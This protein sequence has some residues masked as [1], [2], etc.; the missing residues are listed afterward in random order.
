[1]NSGFEGLYFKHQAGGTTLALIPGRSAREAF[2]QVVVNDRAYYLPYA[3]EEY[4]ADGGMRVGASR[5]CRDG[6]QLDIRG[7]DLTLCGNIR[8]RGITPIRGD[9]MGPFRFFPMECRH[10]VVSMHHRLEGGLIMNGRAL[11]FTGGTGYIEG[12][13]GRSFP[14]SYTWAQCNC[15]ADGGADSSVMASA[16]RIPFLGLRFWGCIA[17]VWHGGREYRLATYRGARVLERTP[18]ELVADISENGIVMSGGG[19]LL[20]GIDRLVTE[21]TGIE[22][23]VADDALSCTAYGAGRMLSRLDSMTDGMQNFARQRQLDKTGN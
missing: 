13:S 10:T 20:Y 8:Y 16:A 2:I 11:N 1:M 15:W 23:H 14:S 19:S 17:A 4:A 22:A 5:F 12:D 3:P 7:K 9:I 6:V 18:P 21:R